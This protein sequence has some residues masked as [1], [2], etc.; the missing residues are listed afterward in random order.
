MI[1]VNN[2]AGLVNMRAQRHRSIDTF[3][4]IFLITMSED[5][6]I[7]RIEVFFSNQAEVERFF[8]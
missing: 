5:D 2:L 8:V 1:G 7:M 6:K 3:R 4:A